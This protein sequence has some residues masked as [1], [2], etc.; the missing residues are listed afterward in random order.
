MKADGVPCTGGCG[1][2][3]EDEQY[4][5]PVCQEDVFCSRECFWNTVPKCMDYKTRKNSIDIF[6]PRSVVDSLFVQL[7][8]DFDLMLQMRQMLPN[9]RTYM[10]VLWIHDEEQ[11]SI[12][13]SNSENWKDSFLQSLEVRPV[14]QR[15]DS[16]LS[17]QFG[18]YCIKTKRWDSRLM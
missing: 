17:F 4:V 8:R 9:P 12:M 10:L 15:V 7:R 16:A 6:T 14:L 5:C 13:L 1:T 2:W 18:V 11:L 3:V